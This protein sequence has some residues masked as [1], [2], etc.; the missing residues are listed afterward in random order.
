MKR[1]CIFGTVLVVLVLIQG[2]AIGHNRVLLATRSN[3]GFGYELA[4]ASLEIALSRF[5]GVIEPVFEGGQTVPVMAS[6]STEAEGISNFLGRVSSTF[7]TGEAAFLMSYLYGMETRY[8]KEWYKQDPYKNFKVKLSKIPRGRLPLGRVAKLPQEGEMRP[9]LF[10]TDTN[11]GIKINWT[12]ATGP[13]GAPTS[14]NIGFRRKE[15]ALA[16]VSLKSAGA[17]YEVDVPSL[18]ATI[19]TN[20]KSETKATLKYLQYFATGSAANNLALQQNV[21]KSMLERMD[22]SQKVQEEEE[23]AMGNRELIEQIV[24]K[25]YA[26][27]NNKGKILSEAQRLNLVDNTVTIINFKNRL[28]LNE[29][30]GPPIPQNLKNLLD[31]ASGLQ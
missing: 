11:L 18:L 29:R 13:L 28:G 25:F 22:P 2:C 12:G 7:S 8:A 9:V 4:P 1:T 10:G 31:F 24:V 5:E 23:V 17:S 30:E 3:V 14:A 19:D 20:V 15:A 6:F 27:E 21:R 16:P 26:N